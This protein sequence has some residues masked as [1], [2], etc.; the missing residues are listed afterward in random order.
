L[1]VNISVLGNYLHLWSRV[2]NGYRARGGVSIL[3]HRKGKSKI[4]NG[5]YMDE[6]ILLV[7]L[8]AYGR[9]N[10]DWCICTCK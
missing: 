7:E 9:G 10:S 1:A 8:V 6:R 4:R 3:I 5:R 2:D